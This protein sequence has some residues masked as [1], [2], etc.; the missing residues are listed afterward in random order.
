VRSSG[1]K[2]RCVQLERQTQSQDS[3]NEAADEAA[4]LENISRTAARSAVLNM[5]A[6]GDVWVQG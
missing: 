2:T 4:L 6:C 1:G 3:D 5:C